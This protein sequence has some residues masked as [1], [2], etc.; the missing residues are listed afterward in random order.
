MRVVEVEGLVR[1]LWL[2][3]LSLQATKFLLAKT[4]TLKIVREQLEARD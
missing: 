4:K 1:E 2:G 3:A